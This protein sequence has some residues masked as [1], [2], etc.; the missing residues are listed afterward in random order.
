MLEVIFT[1]L[2][3]LVCAFYLYVLLRFR[4]EYLRSRRKPTSLTY[5]GSSGGPTVLFPE[6]GEKRHRAGRAS[7]GQNELARIARRRAAKATGT[8]PPA[9]R[10]TNRLPYLEMMLPVTAVVTPVVA[11]SNEPQIYTP[12]RQRA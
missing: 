2:S 12:T 10:Q 3:V 8:A 11:G 4:R 7:R 5:L 1:I 6:K 9:G